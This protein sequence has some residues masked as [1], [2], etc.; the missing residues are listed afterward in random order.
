MLLIE[1]SQR[2][3]GYTCN[4]GTLPHSRT[5][6]KWGL[7]I[8]SIF[9]TPDMQCTSIQVSLLCPQFL[10]TFILLL[11]PSEITEAANSLHHEQKNILR[12]PM[13]YRF[14]IHFV[15]SDRVSVCLSICLS[16]CLSVCLF[17][18]LDLPMIS[19]RLVCCFI[20][21]FYSPSVCMHV[22]HVSSSLTINPTNNL[23][24]NL[25]VRQSVSLSV[26]ISVI[27]SVISSQSV[28]QSSCESIS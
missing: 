4:F 17:V 9:N 12:L 26:C 16:A 7:T 25:S 5:V 8:L 13:K 2:L 10:S 3:F 14:S 22:A 15:K 24:R 1:F 27:Q 18:H 23:L 19:G 28:G 6:A 21:P 20:H 11:K